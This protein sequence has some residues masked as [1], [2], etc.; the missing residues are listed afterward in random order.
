MA[1]FRKKPIIV[2]AIQITK[3][4]LVETLE[5]TMTGN[6]GDWL[7]IGAT[8]ERYICKEDIFPLTFD[9]VED[10]EYKLL[11][12]E[13]QSRPEVPHCNHQQY[14]PHPCDKR[15]RKAAPVEQEPYHCGL[16]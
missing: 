4:T 2:E 5:G 10:L 6:P 14:T 3:I 1:L 8:G 11:L 12:R 7:I 15:N 9:A 16:P 13:Q